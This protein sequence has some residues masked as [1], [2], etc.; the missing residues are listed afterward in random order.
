MS[1]AE[2][3]VL[4]V[5]DDAALTRLLRLY[6]EKEGFRVLAADNGKDGLGLAVSARPDLVIL[7]V[8][9][10][11]LD[12]WEVCRQIRSRSRVPVLMLTARTEEED[13][14]QGFELGADDYV[15]KPFLPRELV[16]R[17]KAILRR[18]AQPNHSGLSR[19]RV[20]HPGLVVDRAAYVA[21]VEGEAVALTPKEFELLWVLASNPGRTFT[22]AQLLDRIWG[23]DSPGDDRTLDVHVNRLRE[24][25][26]RTAARRYIKTVWGVGYKFEVMA[27]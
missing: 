21:Q 8:M 16:A 1:L 18:A 5:E 11:G 15:T 19:E 27:R 24:K 23:Y 6:L 17:V 4:V 10:P 14:L 26:E 3:T 12:G 9:L 20:E 2:T 25:V 7:D 13:R 22:R